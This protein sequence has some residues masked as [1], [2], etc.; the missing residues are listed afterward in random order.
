MQEIENPE[1]AT[2]RTRHLYKAKG[3]SDAW[4]KKHM[5]KIAIRDELTEEW[6]NRGVQKSKD[7]AI[8]TVEISKATFGMALADYLNI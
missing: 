3:Y 6:K 5:R 2:Q 8:L 7:F 1:L 4:I